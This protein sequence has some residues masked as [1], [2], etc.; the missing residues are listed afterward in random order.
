MASGLNLHM[1]ILLLTVNIAGIAV[2]PDH[3]SV[4]CKPY[5]EKMALVAADP[6]GSPAHRIKLPK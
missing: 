6:G 5:K 3:F 2:Q 4:V 1:F